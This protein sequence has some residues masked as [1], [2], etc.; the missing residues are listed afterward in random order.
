MN[1]WHFRDSRD[2]SQFMQGVMVGLFPAIGHLW[3]ERS[4]W[5]KLVDT[6]DAELRQMRESR[7]ELRRE[8]E[9]L[10]MDKRGEG[11]ET[12]FQE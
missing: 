2:V 5:R 8:L 6:K 12:R 3:W 1:I 4:G 10:A 11:P 9:S 7:D